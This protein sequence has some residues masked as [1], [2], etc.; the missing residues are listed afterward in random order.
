MAALVMPDST[1]RN[2]NSTPREDN[3]QTYGDRLTNGKL[4]SESEKKAA[5]HLQKMW[6][7]QDDHFD[8][9]FATWKVNVLRHMGFPN[10]S[11][12]RNDEN[13]W[14]YYLPPGSTPDMVPMISK[15]A[16]IIRKLTAVILADPP[17][18]QVEPASRDD[19][20][21]YAAQIAERIL[22]DVE[23]DTMLSE[24]TKIRRAFTKAS[25]YGSGFIYYFVDP[26]GGG[27]V[28]ISIEAHPAAKDAAN[29]LTHPETGEDLPPPYIKRYVRPDGT[30]TGRKSEA[31]LRDLPVLKSRVLTGRNLRFFP[32][33]SEDIWDAD[34]VLIG[35]FMTWGRLKN[36][37]PEKLA[38]LPEDEE[39]SILQYRPHRAEDIKAW[40]QDLESGR[41]NKDERLVWVMTAYFGQ[42][43]D[44]PHG[45]FVMTVGKR[46]VI[47][48]GEWKN[49]KPDGT[50]EVMDIP[51]TQYAQWDEGRDDPYF[52]GTSELLGRAEEFRV[53]QMASMLDH[54]EHL[55]NRKVFIDIHSVVDESDLYRKDKKYIRY[56]GEKPTFEEVPG[57]PRDSHEWLNRNDAEM[58]NAA[59][60]NETTRGLEAPSVK[61]GR[62]ALAIVQQAHASL[63]ELQQN[64]ERAYRR[65][66]RIKLQLISRF[67]KAPR[68]AGWT[69]EDDE[70]RLDSWSNADLKNA[71]DVKIKPG[72]LSMLTPVA[73]AQLAEHYFSLGMLDQFDM[74]EI[75]ASSLGGT[76]GIEDEP[77]RLRIRRQISEWKNGPPEDWQPPQPQQ[78][79][80]PA[81]GQPTLQPTPDPVLES[82]WQSVPSDMLPD[83]AMIRLNELTKLMNS[84]QYIQK[85]AAWRSRVEQEFQM[86]AQVSMPA[87]QGQGQ[88]GQGQQGQ[89]GAVTP[90]QANMEGS[91]AEQEQ[92]RDQVG[93]TDTAD[94]PGQGNP[95]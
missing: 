48:R 82:I 75:F 24:R 52:V 10:V 86:M 25:D 32:H 37:F 5:I 78:A 13:E 88:Q 90:T 61:S 47:S 42:T 74:Y 94:A 50:V 66:G 73:K 26:K 45:A 76:L 23:S 56:N 18:A 91:P 29:A 17:A 46:K 81:T 11:L 14:D 65:S 9:R 40:D 38:K 60:M 12:Q 71:R 30:L 68:Q 8:K 16:D 2:P 57:I 92:S 36:L 28:P 89:E 27:K 59:G 77:T 53:A 22:R 63:S 43:S 64:I 4:L 72:T 62:H 19:D 34:G 21:V 35:E 95:L 41:Q 54:L 84:K 15:L 79:I 55:N 69:N 7:A 20:E 80:D 58:D 51:V 85:P 6:D 70:F 3:N 31:A 44:Y 1:P 87:A 33:N 67:F 83:Q 39:N 49:E 93:L